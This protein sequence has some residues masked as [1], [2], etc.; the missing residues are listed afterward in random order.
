MK[1]LLTILCLSIAA[2]VIA[3]PPPP[4]V[5]NTFTT[6]YCTDILINC[7]GIITANNNTSVVVN[8]QWNTIDNANIAA[9]V[10]GGLGNTIAGPGSDTSLISGGTGNSIAG[11][12][13]DS[14]V[15]GG[16]G[17][18]IAANSTD[19]F[20]GGGFLNAI[21]TSI[22]NGMIGGGT[23]NLIQDGQSS[24]ISGGEANQINAGAPFNTIGG[25]N[26]NSILMGSP[27]AG[28]ASS[29]GGGKLNSAYSNFCSVA[30]GLENMVFSLAG[31]IGGG[32]HN[33]LA[34]N[35]DHGFIGGGSL[36][37][38]TNGS[39]SAIC[40]GSTNCITNGFASFIGGGYDNHT[41]ASYSYIGAGLS[42]T[43]WV[44]N[45][46]IGSSIGGGLYNAVRANRSVIAG[47]VEN[48]ISQSVDGYSSILGGYRNWS[49]GNFTTI[50]GGR[51]NTNNTGDYSTILGGYSNRTDG[52]VSVAG[53]RSAWAN[54]SGSWMLKD[55]SAGS[56][57]NAVNDTFQLYFTG[58]GAE[59]ASIKLGV[60]DVWMT[61]TNRNLSGTRSDGVVAPLIG[62]LSDTNRIRSSGANFGVLF[63]NSSD[64]MLARMDNNG[65]WG[66]K[67]N[68]PQRILHVNG[69]GTN[70]A[71][72]W[73]SQVNT[74]P[75]AGGAAVV[76]Y[77][78]I[79]LDDGLQ[80]TIPLYR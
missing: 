71:P 45:N 76:R 27:V 30:G 4:L 55:N 7:R 24:T 59:G 23:G 25:G 40:G 65:N 68:V 78:N 53:G 41:D 57:S 75:P 48:V 72:M 14:V 74:N 69:T 79:V 58:A 31:T 46:G 60:R 15:S 50:I 37:R 39:Y 21:N 18:S 5:R 26:Q 10:G 44:T 77:L 70:Y 51:E 62:L 34:T 43:V 64:T 28:G 16:N 67:T 66:F 33:T 3:A 38:I 36:N 49:V 6:N 47:G 73:F 56:Y 11:G 22:L 63:N 8:S 12:C 2:T 52:A 13:V 29:I 35:A 42:N 19:C 32:G 54:G 20:I 80:Y 1:T 61:G 9:Q 17:N